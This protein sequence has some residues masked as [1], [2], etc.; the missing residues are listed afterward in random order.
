MCLGVGDGWVKGAYPVEL[1]VAS[2]QLMEMLRGNA[3]DPATIRVCSY[4][5]IPPVPRRWH[6]RSQ[7]RRELR[8]VAGSR[9]QA[10]Q[11]HD[12]NSARTNDKFDRG[13]AFANEEILLGQATSAAGSKMILSSGRSRKKCWVAPI[14]CFVSFRR[15]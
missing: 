4:N 7:H 11:L 3:L 8:N 10:T 6:A 14:C 9:S 15:L 13:T 1:Q 12:M 2:A 5:C